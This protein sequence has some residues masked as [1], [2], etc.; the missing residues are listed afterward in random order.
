MM[1]RDAFQTIVII[2]TRAL[3]QLKIADRVVINGKFDAVVNEV[4][5]FP[6]Y[7][8]VFDTHQPD[9]FDSSETPDEM[10]NIFRKRYTYARETRRGVIVIKLM[11]L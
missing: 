7:R 9:V 1:E 10:I 6:T 3:Q 11:R 4:Q 5:E 2:N 8:S